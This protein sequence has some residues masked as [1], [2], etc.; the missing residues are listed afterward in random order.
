MMKLKIKEL[1]EPTQK[2]YST[3]IIKLCSE[4]KQFFFNFKQ[5][6]QLREYLS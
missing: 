4:I 3:W 2:I 6:L 5:A 1:N